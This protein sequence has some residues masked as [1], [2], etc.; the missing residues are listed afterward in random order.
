LSFGKLVR[1]IL[2]ELGK[3]RETIRVSVK[4]SLGYY[5]VKKYKPWF[6]E[7]CLKLTD[8]RKYK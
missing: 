6:D 8:Q 4:E 5:E 1:Q 3:G 7:G 2:T